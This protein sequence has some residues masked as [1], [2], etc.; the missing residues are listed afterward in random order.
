MSDVP[1]FTATKLLG[2][3]LTPGKLRG[4]QRISNA[5]GTLTM[6]ATDQNSSMI[7][8]IKDALKKKGENRE[9]TYQEIVEA[10]IV[11]A[12]TIT[13]HSSAVLVDGYYGA[14][15]TMASLSVPR[16]VGLLVRV[17]K[18][19]GKKSKV[20][21]PLGEYEPG[22]SVGKVKRLG[23]DAVKL[24]AQFEPSEPESA[25]HQFA[26][27]QDVYEQ[28]K[29]HD[30]LFLL[31]PVAFPFGDEKK[32]SPS[33]RKR[34]AATVIE[35]AR[36]L[37]P[38]CDVFKAEFPGHFGQESDSELMGNLKALNEASVR[39]WVLLSAGVDFPEYKKQVEMAM[40]AGASGVLGGRAFWKEYFLQDGPKAQLAFA[41][42]ECT[43]RVR[44]I[45]EIVQ[46]KGK[47]WW[48]WYGINRSQVAGLRAAEGWH[49]RYGEAFA[50]RPA[51][52]G[53][54]EWG[55]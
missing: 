55:Y 40:E 37:S 18:S 4:L 29:K 6:V 30:I 53:T 44:Q 16:D 31:E 14:W 52:A 36:Q 27:V 24:L 51:N 41:K 50:G 19:G 32:D 7:A 10:K 34:K 11:L 38:F 21:A 3:G 45:D 42:G 47:A 20:H 17:E 39:P 9:P 25:E 26:F 2:L 22:F 48:D 13:K 15:N 12:S 46:S 28:C 54:E 35:S 23:I 49:L 1:S 43:E 33:F 5:N 8:M